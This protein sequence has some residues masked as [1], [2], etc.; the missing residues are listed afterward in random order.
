MARKRRVITDLDLDFLSG[1]TQPAQEGATARTIKGATG[2]AGDPAMDKD[3][4]IADLKKQLDRAKAMAGMT[5]AQKA[6]LRN[7]DADEREGFIGKSAGERE[8]AM[9]DAEAADPIIYTS[10]RTNKSY[11]QSQRDL[12]DMAKEADEARADRD[13]VA[14]AAK[15]DRIAKTVEK[16]GN[17]SNDQG[18]L[19]EVVTAIDGIQDATKK[20]A[21]MKSLEAANAAAGATAATQGTSA[22]TVKSGATGD[23][24]AEKEAFDKYVDDYAA[25][26]NLSRA[27][28]LVKCVES[29][30]QGR[31]LHRKWRDAQPQSQARKR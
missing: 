9:K 29:D 3:A 19:T 31:Q 8:K 21:A 23:A 17:L 16:L 10:T 18:G 1:V 27:E 6:F 22:R 14:K 28:A 11:R 12:A 5:D 2:A 25:K 4:Q 13:E 24:S 7:L 20:A 26:N 15:A 30:R